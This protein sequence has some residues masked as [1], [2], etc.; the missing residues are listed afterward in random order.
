MD[1]TEIR[2]QRKGLGLTQSQMA[3]V[4]G[5]GDR[6]RITEIENGRNNPSKSAVR[7]LKAYVDGYRP[8]DWPGRA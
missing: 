2:A 7:L 3:H 6:T 5:Y 4:M 8:A 1:P